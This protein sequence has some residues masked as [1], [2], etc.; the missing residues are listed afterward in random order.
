MIFTPSCEKFWKCSTG[1]AWEHMLRDIFL[2]VFALSLNSAFCQFPEILSNFPP[3]FVLFVLFLSFFFNF[4]FL[5]LHPLLLF[6][7]SLRHWFRSLR[8]PFRTPHLI[9]NSISNTLLMQCF[10]N[11][12]SGQP[13][14]A[15][16]NGMDIKGPRWIISPFLIELV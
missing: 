15:I 4:L 16:R 2:R 8:N 1:N 5:I 12:T 6:S 3:I 13:D 7:P 11:N 10:A 9:T 14:K